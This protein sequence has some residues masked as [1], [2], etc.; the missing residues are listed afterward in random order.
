MST[1]PFAAAAAAMMKSLKSVAGT[2][3]TYSRGT[4]S[5]NLTAVP[6]RSDHEVTDTEGFSVTVQTQDWMID[7]ADLV[8]GG[9]AT[10]PQI[11]DRVTIRGGQSYE[12]LPPSPALAHWRFTSGSRTT[13]RIHSKPVGT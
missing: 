7:V 10:E 6:G 5:A 2:A 1:T 12:V 9:A 4:D 13:Y 11:G 8:L 3:V